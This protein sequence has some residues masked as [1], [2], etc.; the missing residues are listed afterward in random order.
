MRFIMS[1]INV[2]L[3]SV[4]AKAWIIIALA[5]FIVAFGIMYSFVRGWSKFEKKE[6]HRIEKKK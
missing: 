3:K 1:S 4:P 5:F 6:I 2:E